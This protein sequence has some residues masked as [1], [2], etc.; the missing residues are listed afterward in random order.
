MALNPKS[1]DLLFGAL[2]GILCGAMF[3]RIGI[4]AA[5]AATGGILLLRILE[6]KGYLAVNWERISDEAQSTRDRLT[7]SDSRMIRQIK[8]QIA[9][10]KFFVTGFFGG[11]V[12]GFLAI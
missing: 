4:I 11:F 6:Q 9:I 1:R 5:L 2:S 8:E 3:N 10:H 12:V 7:D